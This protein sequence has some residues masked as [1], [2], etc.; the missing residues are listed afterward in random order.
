[1]KPPDIITRYFNA[2]KASLIDEATLC[3]SSDARV[4]DEGHNH[5]GI[6][7]IIDGGT[8]PTL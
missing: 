4:E 5:T 2:A 6:Q 1:M 3:F 8:I 7:P